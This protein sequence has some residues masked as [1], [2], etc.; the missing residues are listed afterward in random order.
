MDA[1]AGHAEDGARGEV[2]ALG[3]GDRDAA[4]GR[5]AGE[6]DGGGGVQPERL[7]DYCFEVCEL[8]DLLER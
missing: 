7:V 6:A 2:A 3:S 5:N 4:S 8:L 1:V